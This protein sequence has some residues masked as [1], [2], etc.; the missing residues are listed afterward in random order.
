MNFDFTI[1]YLHMILNYLKKKLIENNQYQ[2][3]SI[4]YFIE[5]YINQ[6]YSMYLY[7]YL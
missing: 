4:D 5:N 3:N 2:Y 7:R 1:K 6:I